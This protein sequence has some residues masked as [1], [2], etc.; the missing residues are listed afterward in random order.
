M[1]IS[2]NWLKDYVRI[3]VDADTLA[4]QMTMLGL[5]IESIERPGAD[6]SGVVVGKILSI[7]PHPNAD[8][9]V[10]CKTDV[11]Q[12]DPLQIICG[13][14]NMS[15]GDK[16]PT[17]V[18]GAR[19]A[20][21]FEIARRK[22]RGIESFGMM[23]AA[24]ELGM[25][26]DH[27]GLIIMDP[28]SPIGVDAKPL[29]GLDDVIFE[30]EVL[31]NRG[32]WASMI[33][34]AR[35]LAALY[36]TALH[37]PQISLTETGAPAA[38][39]SS[40]TN[41]AP[42]LCP[43]YIGRVLTGIRI[44]PSPDWLC[45]R[46]RAAG[47]RPINNV[48]DV[49]NY[50]LLE[51]GHPLHAFDF[52]KLAENRIVVRRA[53]PGEVMPTL[54]GQER[55][56][57]PEMLLIADAA[58][59]QAVA[60]IM[61]GANSEVGESTTRVFLESAYF[62]PI[63]IRRTSRA[64]GL[65]TESSQRFQRGADPEMAL[66]AIN[67]AAQLMQEL[68]GAEIAPGVI[69]AYPQPVPQREV[70]LRYT[71]CDALL[72][73][74]VPSDDQRAYLRALGFDVVYHDAA[75]CT[76]AVPPWRHDVAQEADLIE[77][78]ARFYGFGNIPVSVPTVRPSE[79]RFSPEDKVVRSLRHY[80]AAQGLTEVYNWTF[81][82]EAAVRKANLPDTALNMVALANP[83]SENQATMRSSLLPG[84][85]ENALHNQNHGIRDQALY[86][87]G[88][89]YIPAPGTAL[90][91]EPLRVGILLTGIAAPQHWATPQ[92]PFDFFDLKGIVEALFAF[93]HATPRFEQ[94]PLPTFQRGQ[95]VTIRLGEEPIGCMGKLNPATCKNF[96]LTGTAYVAEIQLAS[97][98]AQPRQFPQFTSIPA[99]PPSMRD[100]AV[101]VSRNVPA[102][103]LLQTVRDAGGQLLASA[104]IFDVY[105][106][107]PVPEDK[108]SVALGLVF[109]SEERTLT[110]ADTQK[111]WDR[112]LATLQHKFEAQL[113]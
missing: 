13:A 17:A 52:D 32:D 16:V 51:T 92:V 40:V 112:I 41:H 28:G 65:T 105:Q 104:S 68:A 64:L 2:L 18:I 89:V 31:P 100:M 24:D 46:L 75:A 35:E 60:G 1:R 80:L 25:G 15:V 74:Q 43:R 102:G 27:S 20:G 59:A 3:E 61:G 66:Y 50:V 88:P 37:I 22:M 77:E 91:A 84:L 42:D 93:F 62:N 56:V 70:T 8:K 19:L 96:D 54:D 76:V 90:P 111:A 109:Q 14:K 83:L 48:V 4:Q 71:R 79:K 72:G 39:R 97:L 21:G 57:K 113:R 36:R 107:P 34:V 23:C 44:A 7:E 11:G 58:R 26:D 94:D 108:K 6:I 99:F 49:T 110:D 5:E 73:V 55:A 63:S 69:D 67:R 81:S 82:S 103:D 38:E 29:L 106:G 10:V 98:L 87:I 78:V 30:I 47:Q 9:L 101:L 53:E 86:E 95:S 12:P 85:L 45:K 33:G